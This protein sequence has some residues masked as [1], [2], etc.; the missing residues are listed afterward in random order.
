MPQAAP[1]S[2]VFAFAAGRAQEAGVVQSEGFATQQRLA[3]QASKVLL[4]PG[5][6][7]C[8]LVVFREDD[9]QDRQTTAY[10]HCLTKLEQGRNRES[11]PHASQQIVSHGGQDLGRGN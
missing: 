4:V 2:E 5:H 6:A 10:F 8:L 3:L 7:F 11:P 9:L 1:C